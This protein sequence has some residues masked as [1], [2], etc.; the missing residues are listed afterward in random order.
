MKVAIKRV[1]VASI[2]LV[3]SSSDAFITTTSPAKRCSTV[4]TMSSSVVETNSDDNDEVE[5]PPPLSPFQRTLRAL[6]FYRRALPVLASYKLKEIEL[7]LKRKGGNVI[8]EEEE[9]RIWADLDELGSKK[10][11]ETIQEMKGFY[12]KTGQVISTRVD[13]FPEAYT[14]KL[15][16]LQ[17]GIEPM[18]FSMVEK[19]VRQELLDGAPLS[20]LFSS[21]DETCLGSA[22]IAQV[23]KATL[24]DGRVCAVKLQRPNVEPKLRGDVSNLKR[25]SKLLSKS[26]PVDYYTVFS[27]LGDALSN[28][29]DFL[30][31]AQAMKK[32][33][34][35]VASCPITTSSVPA[36]DINPPVLVPLPVGELVSKRVL[37]MDFVEGT[38]LNRLQEAMKEKGIDPNSP[39]SKIAG[40]QILDALSI[41]F[42]R[43]IFG[44]GFCHGDPHPGNI[45]VGRDEN[46]DIRVSLIDCG[47]FKSVTRQQRTKLARVVCGVG[48]YQRQKQ[49][50]A[51]SSDLEETKKELAKLVLD[52]GV[53][54]NNDD[55]TNKW[56]DLP[57]AVAIFLFGDADEELPGGYSSNELNENSP[58]KQVKSFPQELVLLGR[59]TVLLKGIAK[60][61]KVQ[62][63]LAD[64]WYP[65]A[66]SA[67]ESSTKPRTMPLWGGRNG[68]NNDVNGGLISDTVSNKGS[69][70]R[71]HQVGDLFKAWGKQKVKRGAKRC[72]ERI[73]SKRL[74]KKIYTKI[75]ER[76]EQKEK[77]TTSY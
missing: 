36:T 45:F 68:I 75:N 56:Y 48:K 76:Q 34:A 49:T 43:M 64:K 6:E 25:I 10:I 67:V 4:R 19:V 55:E 60:R 26:L 59:A 24:L 39:E 21:F 53:E 31:E 46:D 62:F 7:Y 5:F 17:D 38:P 47:Q 74:K 42:G 71:F 72:V 52:F 58:I 77:Q 70:L 15:S 35:A 37:V 3:A 16:V 8:T 23:H 65:I 29:L 51:P 30:V 50:N 20:E 2:L 13:L 12:V 57:A 28:E 40:R 41:A 73:P 32:I 27:E 14:T 63:S 11:S 33:H 1:F 61:L 44:C 18:P 54:I 9:E 22:S 66:S 69:K